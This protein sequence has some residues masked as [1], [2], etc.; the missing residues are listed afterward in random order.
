MGSPGELLET[1][2]MGL[3]PKVLIWLVWKGLR[4]GFPNKFSGNTAEPLPAEPLK[5]SVEMI[6]IASFTISSIALSK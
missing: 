6:T 2:L 1:H 3:I 4:V 5:Q